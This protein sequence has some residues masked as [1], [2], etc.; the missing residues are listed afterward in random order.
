MKGHDYYDKLRP[1]AWPP[2]TEVGARQKTSRRKGYLPGSRAIASKFLSGKDLL[3]DLPG[4]LGQTPHGVNAYNA[5]RQFQLLQQQGQ[6]R[7]LIGML[8]DMALSQ[9]QVGL[10]GPGTDHLDRCLARPTIMGTASGLAINGDLL[11]GQDRVDRLHPREKTGL[12]LVW[13]QRDLYS[14]FLAAYLDPPD[15]LPSSARYHRYWE[16]ADLRLRAALE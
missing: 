1:T 16:G 9:H 2:N 4:D 5:A 14:A 11:G 12:K 7:L 6:R 13:V 3:F 15:Y 10:R 8:L